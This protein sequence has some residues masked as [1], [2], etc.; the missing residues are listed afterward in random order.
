MTASAYPTAPSLPGIT[1]RHVAMPDD[2][3]AM[4][5]VANATRLAEGEEWI[6]SYDQ[7]RAYYESLSNCDPATDIVVAERDGR[8]VSGALRLYESCG[9]V[10]SKRSAIYR[11]PLD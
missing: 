4:N 10:V 8:I 6:T 1:F 11:K 7:F 2:L 9:F 3:G 5:D